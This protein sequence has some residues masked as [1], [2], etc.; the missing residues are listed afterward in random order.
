ME[1]EVRAILRAAL[2]ESAAQDG[3]GTSI[4][5]LFADVGG[6]DLSQPP[7]TDLPRAAELPE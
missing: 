7:R 1:A 5:Q 4:H 6:A 3:L 2:S